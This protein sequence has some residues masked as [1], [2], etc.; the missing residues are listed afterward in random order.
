MEA[1]DMGTPVPSARLVHKGGT[2]HSEDRHSLSVDGRQCAGSAVGF[3]VSSA[4]GTSAAPAAVLHVVLVR[5]DVV[6]HVVPVHAEL[7]HAVA[8]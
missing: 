5:T 8:F 7:L 6:L 2:G 3:F 1:T 4:A